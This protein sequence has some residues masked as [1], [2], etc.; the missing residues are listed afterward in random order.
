[1][2]QQSQEDFRAADGDGQDAGTWR[3]AL[4]QRPGHQCLRRLVGSLL[5]A[6]LQQAGIDVYFPSSP[7]RLLFTLHIA[8]ASC[9]TDGQS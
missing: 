6:G 3:L 9:L 4:C 1:M 5:H 8:M 2:A 7:Q